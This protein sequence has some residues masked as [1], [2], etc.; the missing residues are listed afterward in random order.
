VSVCQIVLN[1][2]HGFHLLLLDDI[3]IFVSLDG[4]CKAVRSTLGRL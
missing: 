4:G 3:I 2:T 1:I